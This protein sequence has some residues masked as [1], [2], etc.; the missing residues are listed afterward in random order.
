V[1]Y[2]T[3]NNEQVK[4]IRPAVWTP[5]FYNNEASLYESYTAFRKLV[6]N[7][8]RITQSIQ[9]LQP[10]HST[11]QATH[12]KPC[13]DLCA[14]HSVLVSQLSTLDYSDRQRTVLSE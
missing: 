11:Y 6:I 10:L 3:A 4:S 7:M 14:T 5:Q 13:E 12:L 9:R 2:Q 1:I 8:Q